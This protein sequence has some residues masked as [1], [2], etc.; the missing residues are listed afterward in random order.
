MNQNLSGILPQLMEF[1][2]ADSQ[3]Y[4]TI[5]EKIKQRYLKN[6]NIIT[7]DNA[8]GFVDVCIFFFLIKTIVFYLHI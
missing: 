1:P 8:Q 6:K 7:A 3:T 2:D 4:E 5:I